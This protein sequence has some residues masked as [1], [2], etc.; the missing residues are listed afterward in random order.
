VTQEQAIADTKI[1][2]EFYR[3]NAERD[4]ERQRRRRGVA[5][6]SKLR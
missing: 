1:L 3:A 5:D 4:M 2:M 6:F